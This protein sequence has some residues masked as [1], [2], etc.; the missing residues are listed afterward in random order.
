M[1]DVLRRAMNNV[2]FDRSSSA[3]LRN[4]PSVPQA[5]AAP[6]STALV[7]ADSIADLQ[8]QQKLL[9]LCL[10]AVDRCLRDGAANW[11]RQGVSL[12]F[13]DIVQGVEHLKELC[14]HELLYDAGDARSFRRIYEVLEEEG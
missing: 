11:W 12:P 10:F 5:A 8:R 13:T 1:L 6:S 2:D 3:A 4:P 7:N 14:L 9:D